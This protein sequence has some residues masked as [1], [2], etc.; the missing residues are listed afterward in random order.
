MIKHKG[1]NTKAPA[2]RVT[3]NAGAGLTTMCLQETGSLFG[4]GVDIS[5]VVPAAFNVT[6]AVAGKENGTR[7]VFFA[8]F[9]PHNGGI[10]F[11]AFFYGL[12]AGVHEIGKKLYVVAIER[13]TAGPARKVNHIE[14]SAGV[15]KKAEHI[16]RK[17]GGYGL[18]GLRLLG[19]YGRSKYRDRDK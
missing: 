14:R 10:L 13:K 5:L 18:R 9:F 17:W 12:R 6:R 19:K 8:V 16:G 1:H 15:V 2:G 7:E 11:A 4:Q 3:I